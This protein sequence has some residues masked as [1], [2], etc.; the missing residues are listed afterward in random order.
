QKSAG[1]LVITYPKPNMV[2][3]IDPTIRPEFQAIYLTALSATDCKSVEWIL[4]GKSIGK[5]TS[6]PH[7]LLWKLQGGAHEL[8]AVTQSG[9]RQSISFLVQ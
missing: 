1:S 8:R 7:R 4:D 5:T 3:A 2:F 6:R 9:F